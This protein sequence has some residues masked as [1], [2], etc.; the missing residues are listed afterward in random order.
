MMFAVLTLTSESYDLSNVKQLNEFCDKIKIRFKF[1]FSL[2]CPNC[3]HKHTI[4]ALDD[5][6]MKS[7]ICKCEKTYLLKLTKV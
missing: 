2:V 3:K 4:R 1:P 7:V 6:P 5:F